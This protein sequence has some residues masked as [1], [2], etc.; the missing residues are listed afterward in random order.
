MFPK[1][2]YTLPLLA[3]LAAADF[4]PDA[5]ITKPALRDNLDYL[6]DGLMNTIGSAAHNTTPYPSGWIPQDCKD[7]AESSNLSAADVEAYIVQ[8]S[9]VSTAATSCG[10]GEMWWNWC[11]M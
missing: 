1:L 10:H 9:D 4:N 11:V 3:A 7:L 8:Y 6:K 5:P 2:T